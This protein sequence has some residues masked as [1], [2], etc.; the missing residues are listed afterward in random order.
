MEDTIIKIKDVTRTYKIGDFE[1][2]ALRGVNLEVKRGEFLSI[3]GPSGSGK[4]TLMNMMGCLDTPTSG[5]YILEDKNIDKL[6]DD[7]LALFRNQKI[8]F[9]SNVCKRGRSKDSRP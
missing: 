2:N 3:M 8:G 5:T 9:E 6:N 7:Q 1:V 4:S